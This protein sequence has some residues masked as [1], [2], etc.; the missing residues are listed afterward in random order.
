MQA[1]YSGI[2]I[3]ANNKQTMVLGIGNSGR[4]DD[5]LGWAFLELVGK[6]GNHSG[7]DSIF[8]ISCKSKM[9]N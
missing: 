8:D 3:I 6:T 7:V 4:Q 5:G 1:D 9:L 2:Q